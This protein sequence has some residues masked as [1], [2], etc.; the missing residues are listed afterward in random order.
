MVSENY[1]RTEYDHCVYF[2]M[3]DNGIFIILV[4]YV[5]DMLVAR[6]RMAEINR[7]KDQMARTFDMKDL[8]A[9]KKIFVME[10]HKNKKNGQIWL[11]Q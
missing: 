5:D 9:A 11:S 3:L 1:A 4:I 10:I 7:L 6:K 8:G 2:K